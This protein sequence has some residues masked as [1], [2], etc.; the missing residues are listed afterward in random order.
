MFP[1][2]DHGDV[3]DQIAIMRIQEE[4][5]YR[6]KDYLADSAQVRKLANKPVDED[7]RVKMCEWCYQVVD[8]CKFRRE[9]VGI[10]MSYL[11][12]YLCTNRGKDALCNRKEYQLA[13]MT[14]LYIAIKIHEPL[15]M[16]TS[17]LADLSRGCYQEMEFVD[18]EQ[19]I[20]Q[21]LKWRVNGPTQLGFVTHFM[22]L[23]PS[24]V[25]PAVKNAIFD[26]ARYQT[27]LAIAEHALVSVKPSE[28][29]LAAV[30]NAVEG[31]DM[32]LFPLKQQGKF[33]RNIERHSEVYVSDVED[34]QAHLSL[35]LVSLLGN[36]EEIMST[37]NDAESVHGDLL[38]NKSL[39]TH[40]HSPTSVIAQGRSRS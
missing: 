18:M 25:H 26:Y 28:V 40:S 20:L 14:A 30:L 10:G 36:F 9:T 37:V 32:C 31:M 16:E 34:I 27:E 1:P 11:D 21:A 24:A 19:T 17:L 33:L 13:A 8:F 12:R 29:A 5:T 35:L 22:A 3:A 4:T 7:C 38:E 39:R 2:M 6:V 23:M 15:E